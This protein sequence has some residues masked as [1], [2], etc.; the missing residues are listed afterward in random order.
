[1]FFMQQV[2]QL[3]LL[4]E[5]WLEQL[6]IL[7][8]GQLQAA[9]DS[10]GSRTGHTHQVRIESNQLVPCPAAQVQLVINQTKSAVLCS[11]W[12]RKLGRPAMGRENI[13]RSRWVKFM[14]LGQKKLGEK[15]T[16]LFSRSAK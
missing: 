7:Q 5:R 6:A 9:S 10:W 8:E 2:D 14:T 1:M 11:L 16:S 12:A 4:L 13:G 15:V 3:Q